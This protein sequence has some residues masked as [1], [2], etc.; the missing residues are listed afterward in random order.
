MPTL[1]PT[2]PPP[3]QE[4]RADIAR[5]RLATESDPSVRLLGGDALCEVNDEMVF[6]CQDEEDAMSSLISALKKQLEDDAIMINKITDP[7]IIEDDAGVVVAMMMKGFEGS[8]AGVRGALGTL[9][10]PRGLGVLFILYIY[11]IS[12]PPMKEGR[13]LA[14]ARRGGVT[15]DPE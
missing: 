11:F 14:R 9:D 12:R 13:E 8:L 10:I 4:K 5:R 2:P 1:T 7:E 3:T 6:E 15:A